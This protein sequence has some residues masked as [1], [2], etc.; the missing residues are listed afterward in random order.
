[1]KFAYFSAA[2]VLATSLVGPVVSGGESSEKAPQ[3]IVLKL[4]DVTT[5]GG[6]GN[7]PVSPRWQRVTDFIETEQPEGVLR[8]HRLVAGAG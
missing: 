8:H 3:I 6:R 2:A 1:M 5:H 4:D 7:L